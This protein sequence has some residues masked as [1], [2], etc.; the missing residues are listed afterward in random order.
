M[1]P[2]PAPPPG[3]AATAW[4]AE[5]G[6]PRRQGRPHGL[7]GPRAGGAHLVASRQAPLSVMALHAPERRLLV[8]RNTIGDDG[9]SWVEDVDPESLEE[10]DRS[11]D[12][13]L[14]PFWPGGMAVLDDGSIAVVQG[15]WAHHLDADLACTA[16]RELPVDASYN[17]FVVLADGSLATKDLQLPDGTPSVLS[18]LDP[19]TLEDRAAPLTLPEPSVARLAA[20]GDDVSSVGVSALHRVRFD[21]VAATLTLLDDRRADYL[22]HAG[23]SYG[24]DPVVDA[25]AIWWMDNGDHTFTDG[26]TMLDNGVAPGPTRLWKV[27]LDGGPPAS[28]E[29]SGLASGA[30]TNPPLVDP[31]RG[32]AVAFD[33]A[34]GVLAA[35]GTDDLDLRW[36]TRL[37]TAQHLWY[38]PDTGELIAND[39]DP[40]TGDALVVVDIT[41]GSVR[42]RCPVESPAQSVVFGAP[43][44]ARDAYYVSLTTLA[45]V[46]FDD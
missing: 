36:R 3:L 46:A 44:F 15:R 35:F 2:S 22:L 21:R 26:M 10:R 13:A 24:W 6:G 17:S 25:G 12:L 28:V 30:V 11:P 38:H 33:S 41:D 9:V 8:L 20:D 4:P 18:I 29:T 40:A 23:Q 14:G 5:D 27:G 37:N 45:H 31:E 42:A 39:H 1:T 7:P 19:I 32:L 34:N 16:S 43:G